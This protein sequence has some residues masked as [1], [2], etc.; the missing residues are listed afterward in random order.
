[1]LA[2]EGPR[3]GGTSLLAVDVANTPTAFGAVVHRQCLQ[4]QEYLLDPTVIDNCT[5]VEICPFLE[6]KHA[7]KGLELATF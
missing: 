7:E 5:Q 1:M 2:G 4:S 6:G 3:Q